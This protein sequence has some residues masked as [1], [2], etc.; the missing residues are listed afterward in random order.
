M[1]WAADQDYL[2]DDQTQMGFD[3]N[4]GAAALGR[5][6]TLFTSNA[7]L[8]GA[9]A[10]W[11]DPSAFT[12]GLCAMQWTGLWAL[13]QVQKASPGDDFGVTAVPGGRPRG[14]PRRAGRRIRRP[15]VSARSPHKSTP[16]RAYVKWLWIDH[17]ATSWTSRSRYGFHI[18]ARQSS[19]ARRT[20]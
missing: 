3:D 10:D 16:R 14:R 12:Q 8:L 6:R 4:R 19:L 9:P 1:L 7:L 18:P 2:S 15:A 17:T 20:S 5:L 13:P 11:S